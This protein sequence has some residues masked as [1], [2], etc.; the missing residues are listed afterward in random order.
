MVH[1]EAKHL[2]SYKSSPALGLI[3]MEQGHS[4]QKR[5][6]VL[7]CSPRWLVLIANPLSMKVVLTGKSLRGRNKLH[8]SRLS[9]ES[10]IFTGSLYLATARLVKFGD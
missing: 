5:V 3:Q 2:Q 10:L 7:N 8:F 1:A 6:K 9:V 4:L